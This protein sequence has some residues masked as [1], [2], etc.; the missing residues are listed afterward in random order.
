MAHT[1]TLYRL[2]ASFERDG[3]SID[4]D[5]DG[6]LGDDRYRYFTSEASASARADEMQGEIGDYDLDPSTTYG[7]YAVA[8]EISDVEAERDTECPGLI[9]ISAWVRVDGEPRIAVTVYGQDRHTKDG[10][11]GVEPT[12]D[13]LYAWADNDILRLLGDDAGKAV[14]LEILALAPTMPSPAGL[15]VAESRS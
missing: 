3:L 11:D 10:I 5:D 2:T 7:Y 15:V 4:A 9:E 12:G 1:M 8:V 14:C 13:D 6:T